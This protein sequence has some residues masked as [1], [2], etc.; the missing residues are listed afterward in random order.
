VVRAAARTDSG[1]DLRSLSG[2]TISIT[3]GIAVS[4]FGEFEM[5]PAIV[6]QDYAVSTCG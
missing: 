2:W 3:I 4:E 6:Q 5:R 1:A